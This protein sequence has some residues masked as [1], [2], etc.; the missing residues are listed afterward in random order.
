MNRILLGLACLHTLLCGP[1]FAACNERCGKWQG[2]LQDSGNSTDPLVQLTIGAHCIVSN[3][4]SSAKGRR[5]RVNLFADTSVEFRRRISGIG[6]QHA[7]QGLLPV[8]LE[9]YV[10]A[11]PVLSRHTLGVE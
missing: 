2:G 3:S 7:Y 8:A 5:Q 4:I 11:H 10:A 9:V 1:A 6:H